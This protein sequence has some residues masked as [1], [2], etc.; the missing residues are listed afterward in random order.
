ME[1]W[2]FKQQINDLA[3]N[4]VSKSFF[5]KEMS[6]LINK[7]DFSQ[8][9]IG[10]NSTIH[11]MT[12]NEFL[13]Y[14]TLNYIYPD[15][16]IT[17]PSCYHASALFKASMMYSDSSSGSKQ[18]DDALYIIDYIFA[19]IYGDTSSDSETILYDLKDLL[20]AEINSKVVFSDDY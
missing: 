5:V 16:L 7:V 2:N 13:L 18:F 12:K 15:K 6:D 3:V 19:N 11:V 20:D 1:L 10:D 4:W 14:D 17:F 8:Q 9:K